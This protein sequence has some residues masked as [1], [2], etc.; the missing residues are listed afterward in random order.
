MRITSGV[1]KGR[2]LELNVR[3]GLRP[4]LAQNRQAV[5][6]ILGN[7]LSKEKVLDLFCGSGIF[8]FE[9]FSRGA[10]SVVFIDKNRYLMQSIRENIERWGLSCD[11]FIFYAH[12][13]PDALSILTGVFDLI[14]MEVKSF[15]SC[16]KQWSFFRKPFLIFFHYS[17]RL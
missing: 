7:N 6:N 2:K 15:F 4:S 13:L 3:D 8:G 5:F 11:P 9:A 14:Y 1:L 10:Q 12:R 16:K 17:Y